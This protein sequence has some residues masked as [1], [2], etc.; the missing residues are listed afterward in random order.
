MLLNN[1]HQRTRKVVR[2][3]QLHPVLNVVD[4]DAGAHAG[5]ELI[6]GVGAVH[7]V[8]N[9]VEGVLHF[10]DVMVIGRYPAFNGVGADGFRR[11]FR[12]LGDHQAVVEG[13]RSFH[14]QPLHQRAVHVRHFQPG[15][16]R[17]DFKD[18]FYNRQYAA[19]QH[20]GQHAYAKRHGQAYQYAYQV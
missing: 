18:P 2:P 15:N 6:M 17:N 16:G 12:Q 1:V 8:F 4:D 10:A 14:L 5:R 9:E 19:D 3:G 13:T 11:R 20:A 7:D